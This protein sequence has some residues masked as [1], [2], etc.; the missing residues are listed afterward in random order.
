[1]KIII[2]TGYEENDVVH[3]V[4]AV[5]ILILEWFFFYRYLY[6]CM[7]VCMYVCIFWHVCQEREKG[8]HGSTYH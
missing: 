6:I 2:M 5:C 8:L 3:M 1:M 7:Y 4:L